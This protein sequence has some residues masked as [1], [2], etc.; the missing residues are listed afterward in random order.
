MAPP[1]PYL[2]RNRWPG[3]PWCAP[4]PGGAVDDPAH[5]VRVRTAA[6]EAGAAAAAAAAA[7]R[8]SAATARRGCEGRPHG[9]V[10]VGRG[11]LRERF[12]RPDVIVVVAEAIEGALLLAQRL[13]AQQNVA[14]ER[15]VEPLGPVL[16]RLARRDALVTDAERAPP[17]R[18]LGESP[19]P[20]TEAKGWPLELRIAAGSPN[21]RTPL[22]PSRAV[23]SF[24]WSRPSPSDGRVG[25]GATLWDT[26]GRTLPPFG[27]A[28]VGSG[29]S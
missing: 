14:L 7:A 4:R 6:G 25:S 18:E 20:C 9:S 16:R 1:A 28:A 26:R 17:G 27:G 29:S 8:P 11:A 22:R 24:E 23:G 13:R 21:A 10:E 15:Q 5:R 3:R 2:G 19:E 12:I